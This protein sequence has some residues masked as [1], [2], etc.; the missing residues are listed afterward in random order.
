MSISR[1]KIYEEVSDIILAEIKSGKL[2]PGD[3]LPAITKLADSYGVSQAS[4]REALNRLKV[5]DVIH[6]KHGHGSFV[7]QQ[8]PLGFEQ[9]FEIITKAD[10]ENLLDLRKIIEVGCAR[11]ACEKAELKDLEKMENALQKMRTAVENNELGE[12]ADYDFHMAIAEATGNPL[13]INLMEDVSDTM[14][15]TMKETR[16]IWLYENKKSIQKIYDE[17]KSIL[18][19]VKDKDAEAAGSNMYRHLKEVEDLLV[20]QY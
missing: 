19:A 20:T 4:I 17:H 3:K 8:M 14:I 10:I 1:K 9:N 5:L 2:K 7:N 16:R 11:S 15:R 6:V 13:L 12:Q 18:K